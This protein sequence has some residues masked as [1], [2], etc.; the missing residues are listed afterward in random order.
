MLD[1]LLQ[2]GVLVGQ[3]VNLILE[4]LGGGELHGFF[5]FLAHTEMFEILVNQSSPLIPS[6]SPSRGRELAGS[7]AKFECGDSGSLDLG[8]RVRVRGNVESS[9]NNGYE[10]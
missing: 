1:E 9:I 5:R 8:E 10:A 2:V 3:L 7:F 4:D 6:P